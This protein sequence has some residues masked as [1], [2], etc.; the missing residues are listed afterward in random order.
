MVWGAI[1]ATGKTTFVFVEKAIKIYQE[2]YRRVILESV[3]IPWRPQQ[4]C[5]HPWILQQDSAPAHRA[6]SVQQWCKSNF[7]AFISSKERTLLAWSESNG[8]QF[9][10]NVR[11]KDLLRLVKLLMTF[12]SQELVIYT[13]VGQNISWESVEKFGK[14]YQ[15]FGSMYSRRAKEG[16]FEDK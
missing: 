2:I 11:G 3:V 5:Y 8:L 15:A 7:S 16:Y 1:C 12:R 4:F 14:F 6:L 10:F 13:R 9:V